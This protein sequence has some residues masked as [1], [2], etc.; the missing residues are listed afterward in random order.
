[1]TENQFSKRDFKNVNAQWEPLIVD[2]ADGPWGDS[3]AAFDPMAGEAAKP[4]P[5]EFYTALGGE[6][7]SLLYGL[8][9]KNR[10]SN[11]KQLN[12]LNNN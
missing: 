5:N 12:R 8:F 2:V 3:F 1:M 4:M 7:N 10:E 11:Q 6:L 9:D